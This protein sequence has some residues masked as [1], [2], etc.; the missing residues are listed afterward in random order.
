MIADINGINRFLKAISEGNLRST[1]GNRVVNRNDEIG[2]IGLYAL[3]M[4][5]NLQK[6]IERDALTELYNRRSGHNMLSAI[7]Q[8]NELYCVVMC[9][10]DFFKKVR[11]FHTEY[12]PFHQQRQRSL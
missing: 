7:S 2:S 4:R 1:L 11:H 10:I 5:D 3:K 6:L 8:K 12:T 9:D